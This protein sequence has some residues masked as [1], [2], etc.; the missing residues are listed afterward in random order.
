MLKAI[1]ILY[2]IM[3]LPIMIAHIKKHKLG[4]INQ[5]S[6]AGSILGNIAGFIMTWHIWPSLIHKL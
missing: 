1:Y 3:G 5:S 6:S 4:T 2:L